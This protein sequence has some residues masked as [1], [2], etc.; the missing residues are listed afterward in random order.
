MLSVPVNLSAGG[1]LGDLQ[2]TRCHQPLYLKTGSLLL[3]RLGAL[4]PCP[5][6]RVSS[7]SICQ[8]GPDGHGQSDGPQ[9]RPD[10][11]RLTEESIDNND[12][13]V[14]ATVYWTLPFG[15]QDA[16]LFCPRQ[17]LSSTR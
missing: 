4:F 3:T 1:G 12:S 15:K 5:G 6:P 10:H 14:A 13:P 8:T 11:T 17:P 16:K 9:V 7:P 2:L